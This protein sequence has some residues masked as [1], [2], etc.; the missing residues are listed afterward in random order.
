MA[1]RTRG[2]PSRSVTATATHVLTAMR[3]LP[4]HGALPATRRKPEPHR[5]PKIESA[6]PAGRRPHLSDHRHGSRQQ[7]TARCGQCADAPGRQ[8]IV[9][10]PDVCQHTGPDC[11]FALA[12]RAVEANASAECEMHHLVAISDV[13]LLEAAANGIHL[14]DT[15][16]LG[17]PDGRTA[18][19]CR[20]PARTG[21][22]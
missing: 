8:C 22:R 10:A 3:R 2:P 19:I 15:Y 16:R 12:H 4:P 11:A 21:P 1:P 6:G 18:S 13:A 17:R 7:G 20:I 5:V 14:P 9:I